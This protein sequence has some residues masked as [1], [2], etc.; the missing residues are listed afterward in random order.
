MMLVTGVF[1]GF[2][3]LN[4]VGAFHV[5][6][7]AHVDAVGTNHFHMFLDHDWCDHLSLHCTER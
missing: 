3:Q 5:V 1:V 4:L 7:G 2:R 6:D